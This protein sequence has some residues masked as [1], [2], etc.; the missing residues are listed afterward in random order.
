MGCMPCVATPMATKELR[1]QEKVGNNGEDRLRDCAAC[2][3][4]D[5]AGYQTA[6]VVR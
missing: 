1:R 4:T 5:G 3:A 6:V 2:I